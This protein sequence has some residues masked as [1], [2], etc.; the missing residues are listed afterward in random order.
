M[1]ETDKKT[2]GEEEIKKPEKVQPVNED[3]LYKQVETEFY[4]SFKEPGHPI[5]IFD[6][7]NE[8]SITPT[9]QLTNR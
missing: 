6:I 5:L 2:L 9:E 7:V 8:S 3:E 4:K 1:E